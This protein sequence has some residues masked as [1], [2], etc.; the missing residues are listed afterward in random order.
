VLYI[1]KCA[2]GLKTF[3]APATARDGKNMLCGAGQKTISFHVTEMGDMRCR[4]RSNLEN[5]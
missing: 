2:S 4:S 5:S 1:H 3:I